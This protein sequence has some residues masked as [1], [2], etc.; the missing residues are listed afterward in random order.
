MLF[1]SDITQ[2]ANSDVRDPNNS[3][4]IQVPEGDAFLNGEI[5]VTRRGIASGTGV[6]GKPAEVLNA[7]TGWLDASMVYGSDRATASRLRGQN[8]LMRVSDGDNLPIANF[9][10]GPQFDAGDNRAA[11]NPNLTALQTLFILEHNRLVG[12]LSQRHPEWSSDELYEHA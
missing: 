4:N 12:N 10:R 8:G 6:D 3:I 11:E 5:R 7:V 9:G 2:M 1:R